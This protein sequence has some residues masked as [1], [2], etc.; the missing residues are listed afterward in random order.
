MEKETFLLFIKDDNESMMFPASS[1]LGVDADSDTSTLQVSFL[2]ETGGINA[3]II[4]LGFTG[5]VKDACRALAGA[6]AGQN[7]GLITIADDRAG[8]HLAPF[9]VIDSIA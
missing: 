8:T 6:L 7:R 4:T 3:A 9:N 1:F 5:A 2:K